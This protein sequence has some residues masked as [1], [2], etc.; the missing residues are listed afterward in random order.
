MNDLAKL[1]TE[2]TKQASQI[3]TPRPKLD[4]VLLDGSGSMHGRWL[5]SLDAIDRYAT[6]LKAASLE[7][8][9]VFAAF[10]GTYGTVDYRI[11]RDTSSLSWQ[12]LALEPPQCPGGDTPLYDAINLM[13]RAIRNANP[14]PGS[15]LIVTD[16]EENGSKTTT[17]AQACAL[18][19]WLRGQG[20][21]ITFIGCDF[22][23]LRLAKLLG[24][25]AQ[26]AIGAPTKRLTDITSEL[27]RKRA[28]HDKFG[29]PMH[30][31]DEE[32]KRF[33]G[34][35]SDHSNGN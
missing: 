34:F 19:D 16:G 31:S 1:M 32:K 3:T 2:V 15:I 8:Q 21:Q 10:S 25:T 9:L 12:A 5:E 18:L 35:L 13:V 23:N 17:Q 22:N 6:G 28:F 20:W 24:G 7:T 27:A 11:V 29:T 33:G 26:N 14:T 30:F 4:Y